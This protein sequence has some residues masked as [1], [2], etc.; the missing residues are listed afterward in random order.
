MHWV[1]SLP[2]GDVPVVIPALIG[3]AASAVKASPPQG[4]GD[5]EA[6]ST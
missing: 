5:N 3:G 4:L 6:P 2:S 1:R